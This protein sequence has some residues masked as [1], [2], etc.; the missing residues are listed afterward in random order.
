MRWNSQGADE[1]PS[2]GPEMKIAEAPR[3]NHRELRKLD[4]PEPGGRQSR[5][6][7]RPPKAP[8]RAGRMDWEGATENRRAGTPPRRR[9]RA[10]TGRQPPRIL[11]GTNRRLTMKD[12]EARTRGPTAPTRQTPQPTRPAPDGRGAGAGKSRK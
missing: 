6:P 9:E 3:Q 4:E 12:K 1:R 2:V 8:D 7:G 5:E 11:R 10:M